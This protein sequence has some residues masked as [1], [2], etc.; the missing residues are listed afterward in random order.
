MIEEFLKVWKD[1]VTEDL[2]FGLKQLEE[3][4]RTDERKKITK[5]LTESDYVIIPCEEYGEYDPETI[6]AS[7]M[8]EEYKNSQISIKNSP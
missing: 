1:I 2:I 4:I 6:P 8:M 5:W 7:D 3:E